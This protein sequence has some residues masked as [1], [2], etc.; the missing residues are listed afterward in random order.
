MQRLLFQT[1]LKIGAR[2]WSIF[3]ILGGSEVKLTILWR[4]FTGAWQDA[5]FVR[6]ALQS[7][8]RYL[9]LYL[10]NMDPVTR[11]VR[12]KKSRKTKRFAYNAIIELQ[13]HLAAFHVNH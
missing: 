1:R 6:V 11:D 2:I 4:R 3:S 7:C 8:A 13:S 12:N 5:R 9:Q 10:I